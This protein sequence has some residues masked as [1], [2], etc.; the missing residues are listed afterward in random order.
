MLHR[1]FGLLLLSHLLF[2]QSDFDDLDAINECSDTMPCQEKRLGNEHLSEVELDAMVP[3][4]GFEELDAVVEDEMQSNN[5][6]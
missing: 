4:A 5:A 2:A 1:F 6:F 3:G